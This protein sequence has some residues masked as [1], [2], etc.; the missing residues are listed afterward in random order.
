LK[1]V[2]ANPEH[3]EIL[4]QGVEAWNAWRGQHRDIRPDLSGADLSGAD[5][6]GANLVVANL[7]S[8]DLAGADLERAD[9]SGA[10]LSEANL[11]RDDLSGAILYRAN[12]SGAS[13]LQA[14]LYH[15]ILD[16]T[17]LSG[18]NLNGANLYDPLLRDTNLSKA[19][20]GGTVFVN[21]NLTDVVGLETCDHYGPSTL[22]HRTLAKSGPLPLAFLRGCGLNDW[23]VE[24]TKLYQGGLTSAQINDIIYRIYGLRADLSIQFHSCFISYAS[25]DQAF[26]ERL[27][28]NL[29]NKGVRC[30]YAPEDMKIGDEFRSRIDTSIHFHDRLL[31]ILSEYSIRSRWVQKEVE[32][33]FEKEA[34]E[35]R[36]VLFPIRLDET[37]MDMNVGWAAD[38]RRQR[39]IGDFTQWKEQDAYQ[40][41]FD[42][43][44]RD[45]KVEGKQPH[46]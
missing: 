43:L 25:Q 8:A 44:L 38:I 45:L 13:L 35:H 9:L 12:L 4:T 23:E 7:S 36:L 39:Q 2:M 29:Q 26:A 14:N 32:T 18:A 11:K 19:W 37:I 24:V 41:A 10:I 21:T 22:D 28:A 3:L 5:L 30:W 33:A 20:I 27:Y 17:N 34:K 46:G 15:A 6:T 40:Q 31:L 16:S 42:R 1:G